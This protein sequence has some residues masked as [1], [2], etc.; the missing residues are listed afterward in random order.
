MKDDPE[1]SDFNYGFT[2]DVEKPDCENLEKGFLLRISI[3]TISFQAIK[4]E[5]NLKFYRFPLH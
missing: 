2:Y 3:Y 5:S 4:S 1:G